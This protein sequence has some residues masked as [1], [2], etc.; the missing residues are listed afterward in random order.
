MS[1]VDYPIYQPS[2]DISP[3]WIPIIT[4]KVKKLQLRPV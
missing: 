4:A 1:L 3:V 2:L